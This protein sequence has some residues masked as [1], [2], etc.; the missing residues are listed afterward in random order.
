M[1]PNERKFGEMPFWAKT[2]PIDHR[3]YSYRAEAHCARKSRERDGMHPT[4]K[5]DGPTIRL[6]KEYFDRH[7]G[8][9]PKAFKMLMDGS[10]MEMTVPEETP[11]WFDPSF[12]PQAKS[13]S[14]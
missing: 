13:S 5:R 9:R 1:K 14:E 4:I 10:I 2:G 7:L 12:E 11:Q 8:G 3:N 6:W